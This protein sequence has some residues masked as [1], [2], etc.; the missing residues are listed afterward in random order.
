MGDH[1]TVFLMYHELEQ[2]GRPLCQTA[3]GYVRY[4]LHA[5]QFREQMLL[6]KQMGWRGVSVSEALSYSGK[7]VAITFDDGCETDLLFA[8]PVLRE[9][10]FGATFYLTTG[11]VGK[12]GFL[13]PA[14][15][16]ELA[17]LGF[18][19]GCHS[20]THAYLTDL[21]DDNLHREIATAKSQLEQIAGRPVDHFSCPGGRHN[22]RV[23][24]MA[25][26]AGYKTVVTSDF[27]ANSPASD[28]YALGRVAVMH[29][30]SPATVA[31]LCSGHGL[32]AH[33]LTHRVL[34]GARRLLGN[35]IYDRLR[36]LVLRQNSAE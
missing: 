35:S 24:E 6:L 36:N 22:R 21:D 32:R 10:G 19:L 30:T 33:E 23:S 28:P 12:P 15:V 34:D 4:V 20:M 5:D 17:A 9:C 2:P 16:Q 3:P 11:F 8:A 7:N 26:R 18:E 27:H 31:A 13:Q 25:R 14:Q 1:D 29:G